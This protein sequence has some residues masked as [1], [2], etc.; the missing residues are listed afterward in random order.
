M[1]STGVD[2]LVPVSKLPDYD[3][4]PIKDV[5]SEEIQ[6]IGG[7]AVRM[8]NETSTGE[9]LEFVKVI[10]GLEKGRRGFQIVYTLVLSAKNSLGIVWTYKAKV[11]FNNRAAVRLPEFEAVLPENGK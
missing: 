2:P 10:N 5:D 3:T 9:N 7:M 6:G 4:V 1:S 8:H 11:I